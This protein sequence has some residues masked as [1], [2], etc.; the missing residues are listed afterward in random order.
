M[1]QLFLWLFILVSTSLDAKTFTLAT[2]NVQ[3]LFDLKKSGFEYIDYIPNTKAL[4]NKKNY[5]IKLKRLSQAINDLNPDIIALQEIESDQ[6]LKDLQVSLNKLHNNYPYRAITTLK[7]TTVHTAILSKFPILSS[8][9]IM[10]NPK[11]KIRSILDVSL[12]IKGNKF[13][14]FV[15]HWKSKR[16]PESKR[17][18]YGKALSKLIKK[19]KPDADY[20]IV[21]DL[22]SNYNEYQSFKKSQKFNNTKG[23]TAINHFLKT[24]HH[25][26]MNSFD[27]FKKAPLQTHYNLWMELPYKQRWS[28]LFRGRNNSLDHI[29][30]PKSLIDT[31]GIDYVKNSFKRFM[32]KYLVKKRKIFKWKF[33]KRGGIKHHTGQGYSDHLPIVAKFSY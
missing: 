22:N 5:H 16:G 29:I 32:P 27:Y 7:Q 28:Y 21:G 31:Q 15:N 2:Y 30:I 23:V 11:D 24:I 14:I 13:R 9:E 12:D 17:I 20:L 6:A 8:T 33:S 4:W 19:I 26:Q 1:R 10:V 18:P 3:N 25:N